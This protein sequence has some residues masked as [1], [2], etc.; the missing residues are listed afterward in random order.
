MEYAQTLFAVVAILLFAAVVWQ[1]VQYVQNRR[2]LQHLKATPFPEKFRKI[3]D[4]EPLYTRLSLGEQQQLHFLILRFLDEKQIVGSQGMVIDDEVRVLIAFFA[5]ML[6]LHIKRHDL[7]GNLQTVVVYPYEFIM[8]EVQS[9]GGVYTKERYILEGQSAN[10]TVVLSWHSVK[11]ELRHPHA[12]NVIIHEFAHEIDFMDGEIDGVPPMSEANFVEWSKVLYP[13]FE[14]LNRRYQ[15]GRFLG[16]YKFLGAYAA[17]NEAEFF[18]VATERFF[19]AP[20]ALQKKFPHLYT[21]LKRF[22]R[23]DPAQS[24]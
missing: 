20:E 3:I 22:Y 23:F 13:T 9:Y 10:D 12:S 19:M 4:N 6:L 1:I 7:F 17:S 5:C 21:V 14:R 8:H 11:Q 2:R 18:A 24:S 15:K 16:R